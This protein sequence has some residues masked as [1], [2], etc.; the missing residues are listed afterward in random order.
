MLV[1]IHG[2]V[3]SGPIVGQAP[4]GVAAKAL[5]GPQGDLQEVATVLDYHP[6]DV[7]CLDLNL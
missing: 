2:K 4:G 1:Y 5:R 6:L 7:M 3:E